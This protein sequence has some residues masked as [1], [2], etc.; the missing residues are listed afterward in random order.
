MKKEHTA[1]KGGLQIFSPVPRNFCK[2]DGMYQELTLTFNAERG[3]KVNS[4]GI[5]NP[6]LIY[7]RYC[8]RGSIVLQ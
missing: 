2:V 4:S 8:I 5:L 6:K 1:R 7:G 3:Y